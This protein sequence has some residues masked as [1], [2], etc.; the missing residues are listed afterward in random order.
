MRNLI[1]MRAVGTET[2][3]P[4]PFSPSGREVKT[5][6][7]KSANRGFKSCLGD[8]VS[9]SRIATAGTKGY[10]LYHSGWIIEWKIKVHDRYLI[11]TEA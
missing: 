10:P 5:A 11:L 4:F 7:S 2:Q 6:D 8:L 1:E 3:N 9:S